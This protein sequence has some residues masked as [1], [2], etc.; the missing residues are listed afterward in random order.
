MVKRWLLVSLL[1]LM[2]ARA[3]S[4]AVV[5]SHGFEITLDPAR[6]SIVVTDHVE[7]PAAL[8]AAD[9][10]VDFSLN[11]MFS[12][13]A[14]GLVLTRLGSDSGQPDLGYF[15]LFLGE[16]R[17]FSLRYSGR[18]DNQPQFDAG[19]IGLEGVYLSAA[20]GWYPRFGLALHRFTMTVDLPAGW[21]AVSQGSAG[22]SGS[23]DWVETRPQDE[24]YLIA[25]P[26]SVYTRVSP[27]A[28]A[29]VYL[30]SDDRD[31]AERYLHATEQYL[32]FY[33]DLLGPYPYLKFALVENFWETGYGMPSFTLLG[34]RVVRLPF[35]IHTSYPHEIL[36]N[37]WGNGVYVDYHRGNWSEGLTAYLADHLLRE[38]GG[39]GA[40]YRRDAMQ[41]Y[42]S[43]VTSAEE[44]P[45]RDFL[46]KHGEM[47]QAI[48]YGKGLMFF[49]MLRHRLGDEV[50]LKGLRLF[51]VEH[52]FE[53]AGYD[54]LR[55]A[56]EHASGQDLTLMFHQWIDKTGAPALALDAVEVREVDSGFR[57]EARLRQ[58][59]PG[60]P[61]VLD[62][63]IVVQTAAGTQEV[64]LRVDTGVLE[65]A[66]DLDTRPYTLLIDPR[67]DVFRRLDP[68]EIPASL[69]ELLGAKRSLAVLPGDVDEN[70]RRAY[71]ELAESL[72]ATT[73][74][75]DHALDGLP[76]DAM[77]WLLGWSN[78][79]VGV[80]TGLLDA[81]G[82]D[83][84]PEYLSLNTQRLTRDKVCTA[85]VA[86]RGTKGKAVAFVGCDVPPTISSLARRLPHYGKYSYLGFD[87]ES[88]RN[89]VKGN[90]VVSDSVMSA[91]V[92]GEG[93]APVI[94]LPIRPKLSEFPL[95]F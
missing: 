64:S 30:R 58:T 22:S 2:T 92:G 70:T 13:V 29:Q 9:G 76:S 36:H 31:L 68:S 74:V 72:G 75:D 40:D 49:H 53:R 78:R 24:I 60:T 6:G 41:K 83:L 4:S 32:A 71:R 1:V 82:S 77:V 37:W 20:A 21:R 89:L 26:W 5:V 81:V 39:L 12:P 16:S 11:R 79:F 45:L 67:F 25:A 27:L 85:V 42:R 86:R 38:L 91:L 90:W 95:Q 35:I 56:F 84:S 17:V 62:V 18:I 33:Q 63:P 23:S 48:G 80:M 87:A 3:A 8:V 44:Y 61:Y 69:D 55:A 52:Q 14:D 65:F 7:V 19:Y 43:Y 59:Q 50:F 51:F 94:T 66:L 34:P 57:V 88:G 46:G 47:S 93:D 54:E 73:I 10:S 15:R 28:E